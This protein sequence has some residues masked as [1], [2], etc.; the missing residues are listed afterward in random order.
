MHRDDP[1]LSVAA[2][3]PDAP[4]SLERLVAA[5]LAKDPAARPVRDDGSSIGALSMRL[6][7]D[8]N[9]LRRRPGIGLIVEQQE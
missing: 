8:D 4:A 3:R 6:G 2:V 7:L 9:R 1:P 5:T